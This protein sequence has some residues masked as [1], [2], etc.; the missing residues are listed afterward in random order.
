MDVKDMTRLHGNR[1]AVSPVIATVLMILIVMAGMTIL[2]A[3]VG[4]YAQSFHTGSGS[5]VLE[6]L[7]VEDTWFPPSSSNTVEIWVYN[8][9]KVDFKIVNIY[10][11]DGQAIL[12]SPSVPVPVG[13]HEKIIVAPPTGITFSPGESYSYKIVTAR[14]SGFEGTLH[15]WST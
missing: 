8:V 2:F 9:G 1:R 14:G 3:F 15:N 10:I 12:I 4:T 11:D 6:S 13:A 5:A 7:T